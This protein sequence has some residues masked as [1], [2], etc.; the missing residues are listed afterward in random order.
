MPCAG[1][2]PRRSWPRRSPGCGRPRSRPRA[3][4]GPRR[5]WPCCARPR[6][7]GPRSISS[8]WTNGA[9]VSPAAWCPWPSPAD[10]SAASFRTARPRR[11]C[12]CTGSSR[13]PRCDSLAQSMPHLTVSIPA[14]PKEHPWPMVP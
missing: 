1:R 4:R 7:S 8:P 14:V 3:V 13:P 9:S 2:R 6:A 5:R 10:A 11:W 12:R